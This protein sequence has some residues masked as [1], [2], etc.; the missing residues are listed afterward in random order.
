MKLASGME[1]HSMLVVHSAPLRPP[2]C[3]EWARPWVFSATDSELKEYAQHHGRISFASDAQPSS[4]GPGEALVIIGGGMTAGLLALAALRHG[5]ARVAFLCR[6]TLHV[7]DAEVDPGW[8]G[9][10]LCG[11]L[12]QEPNM[13]VPAVPLMNY[14]LP[15]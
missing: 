7:R 11:P 5:A 4:V 2:V 10:K 9:S 6:G 13:Q 15:L 12:N 8:Y 3:P 1:L 14:S